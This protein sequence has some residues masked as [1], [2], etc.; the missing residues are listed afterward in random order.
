M[1]RWMTDVGPPVL[2]LVLATARVAVAPVLPAD[3]PPD[4]LAYTLVT[5]MAAAL[6]LRRRWPALTLAA[7]GAL[8]IAYHVLRYPGGAP[9]VPVW[10][11][12]YAVAVAPSRRPGLAV[13]GVLIFLDA[14]SRMTV[15]GVGP[16]DATLDGST[17]IFVAAL[18]LGEVVRGRRARL[19]LVEAE[20]QHQLTR[21]RIRIARELHDVTAH[22]LAVVAVQAGVAAELQ[23]DD[24][25]GAS[26]ALQSV[27][28]ASRDAM[29]ELRAAVG[30]LRDGSRP[31]GPAP[32]APTL[33]RLPHLVDGT[34]AVLTSEGT[35]R[36]LP[37]AVEATAY[38][39][40][41]EAVANAVRHSGARR[42]EV[43]LGYLP[44]GLSLT[45]TDDGHGIT[46]PPG[47]GLH[48]MTERARGLG[49]WL[50]ATPRDER[51]FEVRGWLPG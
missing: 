44:D 47:N 3:R 8:F 41:Q 6:L 10:I 25:D 31:D 40:V 34:G 12:L 2:A 29:A 26:R 28:Q 18:L 19:A 21:E 42:I 20:Q 24:P 27:R 48:G 13:A 50:H 23:R 38:R 33:D 14:Q 32:P 7:V 5:A 36:P 15:S 46:G 43:R 9:A 30:V 4:T 22:T 1:R 35:P 49:G 39:I 16:L 17:G 37:R 11:A 51:G 45:V